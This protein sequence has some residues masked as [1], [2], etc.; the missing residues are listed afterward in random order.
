MTPKVNEYSSFNFGNVVLSGNI[1]E[2][3]QRLYFWLLPDHLLW[4]RT[5][6]FTDMNLFFTKGLW[7]K[8]G[9]SEVKQ[10]SQ[11]CTA[12]KWWGQNLNLRQ[13]SPRP[14]SFPLGKA[15]SPAE[16]GRVGNTLTQASTTQSNSL[17]GRSYL[18][19]YNSD[20]SK[21]QLHD[22]KDQ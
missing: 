21:L 11:K 10:F 19:H 12:S 13:L 9:L 18:I 1:R 20:F 4:P 16:E 22:F 3:F 7:S 17:R 8:M 2:E 6:Y 5:K 14:L 15:E